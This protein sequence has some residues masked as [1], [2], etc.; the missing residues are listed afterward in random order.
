MPSPDNRSA[1]PSNHPKVRASD[2]GV[3]PSPPAAPGDGAALDTL[4]ADE[5][6]ARLEATTRDLKYHVQAL[7]HEA[8]TVL[9]DVNVGGR[10]AMDIVRGHKEAALAAA[11]GAGATLGLLW[12]LWK[13]S[14]RRPDPPDEHIEFVR[15][16]LAVAL[17]E[18]A[19]RVARGESVDHA[20]RRSMRA[21]PAVFGDSK[22]P[23]P[24]VHS[25]Q[26]LLDVALTTAVGFGVKTALDLLAR[27]Y[28]DSDEA[29]EALAD[30]AD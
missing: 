23:E 5:I 30:A 1:H 22:R 9:D 3:I 7:K 10:P 25:R 14:R 27:R 20:M 11:A 17:D 8:A 6:E 28:T 24:V 29:F 19:E 2:T 16:R 15:A 26:T 13:R 18:A 21:V 4:T 12:G